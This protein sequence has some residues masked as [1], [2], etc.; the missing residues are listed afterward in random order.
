MFGGAA[1]WGLAGRVG[2]GLA[3]PGAEHRGDRVEYPLQVGDVVEARLALRVGVELDEQLALILVGQADHLVV[4]NE[5][6]DRAAPLGVTALAGV[7][8]GHDRDATPRRRRVRQC[9]RGKG[10]SLPYSFSSLAAATTFCV[11]WGGASS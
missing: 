3:G 6:G 4:L 7:Q 8:I 9:R 11:S 1:G 2:L 5:V 10:R